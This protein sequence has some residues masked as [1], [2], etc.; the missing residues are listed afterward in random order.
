MNRHAAALA[1]ELFRIA[2][3]INLSEVDRAADLR[4]EFDI[5]SMDFLKLVTA[6]GKRYG[7]DMPE[8]DYS[9]MRSFD[10]LAEYLEMHGS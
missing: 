10:A 7:I 2:P 5:D 4:E 3:E 1:E 6:L 9:E 8:A